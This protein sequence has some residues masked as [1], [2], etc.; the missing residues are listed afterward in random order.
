MWTVGWALG[1][2]LRFRSS[3]SRC[4]RP[5]RPSS[6]RRWLSAAR[7]SRCC[8]YPVASTQIGNLQ[9]GVTAGLTIGSRW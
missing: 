4:C 9:L 3:S 7:V 1:D 6:S 2:H 5:R 8:T